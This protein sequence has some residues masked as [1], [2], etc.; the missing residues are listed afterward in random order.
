M[1]L[2]SEPSFPHNVPLG[3]ATGRRALCQQP[4][5]SSYVALMPT[6]DPNAQG[7][8]LRLNIGLSLPTWSP[9]KPQA[10][11]EEKEPRRGCLS[12]APHP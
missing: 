12:E 1:G 6:P 10:L 11:P 4:A 7:W 8:E 2:P 5:P 9:Q 3:A